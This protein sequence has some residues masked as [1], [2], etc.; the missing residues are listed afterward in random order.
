M[1]EGDK[2]VKGDP[3]MA[4][5]TIDAHETVQQSAEKR[6]HTMALPPLEN[7]D[8]LT[9]EEFEKR[10]AAMPDVKKAELI[11]GVVYMGSPVRFGKHSEPHAALLTWLGT[12]AAFTQ[13][14]R[15]GD[16]ATVRLDS[17]TEPQPDALLR[18]E[19]EVGGSSHISEDDYI[20]GAPEL[21][22]EI[23]S[24]TASYDLHDKMDAYRRAGVKEYLVWRVEDGQ[25]DWFV[26][27]DGAYMRLAPDGSDMISSL[28]F[29]GLWLAVSALL[30]GDMAQVVGALQKGLEAAEHAAFVARLETQTLPR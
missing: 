3:D 14:V 2:A 21:V 6:S 22:A 13:G 19:P 24:S 10:Y 15:L 12:Y 27:R 23:S 9:R 26:L 1:I 11:D 28:T 18:I 7:G 16:N 29:P 17:D 30:A 8:R 25:V 5:S 4:T 20:E